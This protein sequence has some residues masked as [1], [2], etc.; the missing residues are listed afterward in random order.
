VFKFKR[1]AIGALVVAALAATAVA[2]AGP[3]RHSEKRTVRFADLNSLTG[4]SGF[5]GTGAAREAK[6][7]ADYTNAHGG[8]RDRCGNTYRVQL[9]VKDVANS[10][11]QSVAAF[12]AAAADKSVL[13]VIGSPNDVV[14]LPMI[15]LAGQFRLPVVVGTVGSPI[16]KWNSWAFRTESE[17][18]ASFRAGVRA[19]IKNA[20]ALESI[21]VIYDA[22]QAGQ[23][24]EA[25]LWKQL[26]GQFNYKVAAFTSFRAGDTDFKAQLTEIATSG[27]KW[28]I[29]AGVVED[30]AR[31]FTQAKQVGIKGKFYG[32]YSTNATPQ[33]WDLSQGASN[34][35]YFQGP[36]V[37]TAETKMNQPQAKT[38]Y[39][40]KYHE[41]PNIFHVMG[42]NAL[43]A[44]LD[45][46]KRSCTA[47][48]R[49]KFRA[50]LGKTTNF[51]E[52]VAGTKINWKNPPSGDNQTPAGVAGVVTGKTT[53]KVFPS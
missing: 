27:A 23:T 43:S 20:G 3:T 32:S 11:A 49:V 40:Q 46:V 42:W 31:I 44:S 29:V 15:A 38:L 22:S 35:S 53:V 2:F 6:L 28:L 7:L 4:S 48:D 13:G 34:G 33:V 9:S 1:M 30:M 47:T 51:P 36:G 26:A 45:A 14:N 21:G 10:K 8:F 52:A 50:A 41:Y 24:A 25:N 16:A 18:T 39:F 12:R 37:V 19:L 5:Y 17:V